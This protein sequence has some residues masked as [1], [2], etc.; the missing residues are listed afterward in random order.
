[1][2]CVSERIGVC[3]NIYQCMYIC[4]NVSENGKTKLFN[5]NLKFCHPMYELTEIVVYLV[6]KEYF[7]RLKWLPE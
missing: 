3:I 4:I 6:S 5:A 1:M 2:H 7:E